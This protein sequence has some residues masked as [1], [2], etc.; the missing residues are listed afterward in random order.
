MLD[1]VCPQSYSVRREADGPSGSARAAQL[2]AGTVGSCVRRRSGAHLSV[3]AWDQHES[4]LRYR[5]ETRSRAEAPARHL[6]FRSGHGEGKLMVSVGDARPCEICGRMFRPLMSNIRRGRGKTC[7][8]QCRCDKAA[9]TPKRIYRGPEHKSW[10]G[11]KNPLARNAHAAIERRIA[12][13]QLV[14]PP[15]SQCGSVVRVEAH[16]PD[17][18][19]P[20][21]VDWLCR[22]CHRSLHNNEIR[23]AS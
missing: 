5:S 12:S 11:G 13:G 23:K 20:F 14:R 2:D 1:N 16:H 21:D 17:Y 4:N 6:G 7:S 8:V 18:C 19:K 15:C 10:R 22:S 3:G 9:R